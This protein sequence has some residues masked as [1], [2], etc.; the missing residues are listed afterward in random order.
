MLM[1]RTTRDAAR[2]AARVKVDAAWAAFLDAARELRMLREQGASLDDLRGGY[3]RK[4]DALALA[5]AEYEAV[6]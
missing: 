1:T 4:R 6:A 5:E 2:A 3:E